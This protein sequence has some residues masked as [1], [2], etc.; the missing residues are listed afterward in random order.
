MPQKVFQRQVEKNRKT[1]RKSKKGMNR[2]KSCFHLLTPERTRCKLGRNTVIQYCYQVSSSFKSCPVQVL[3]NAVQL[4]QSFSHVF[5]DCH[6]WKHNVLSPSHDDTGYNVLA[7]PEHLS[8]WSQML[9]KK[10]MCLPKCQEKQRN[11]KQKR[12]E[13]AT[14]HQVPRE[15]QRNI[16]QHRT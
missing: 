14:H 7:R 12:A 15:K 4:F 5:K 10:Y 3:S 8:N 2:F 6:M 9:A 13:L 11:I 16:E 1:Q